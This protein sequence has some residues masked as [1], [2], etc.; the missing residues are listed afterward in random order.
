MEIPSLS[1]LVLFVQERPTEG[2]IVRLQD[3]PGDLERLRDVLIG[4]LGLGGAIGLIAIAIG[5][6]VG[7]LLFWFRSRRDVEDRSSGLLS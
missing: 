6:G 4:S 5:I 7:G 3:P 2:I 1:S